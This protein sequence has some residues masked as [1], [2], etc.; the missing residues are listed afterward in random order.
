M[1][2]LLTF[3]FALIASVGI[4]SAQNGTCGD[5]LTWELNTE[6]GILTI[7]G[8][9]AMADYAHS[10]MPWYKYSSS[11]QSV[12][13]TDGVTSIG[14]HAFYCCFSLTSIT[15]PNGVTSIG[16]YA[17]YSCKS[18]ASITIPN[19]VTSIGNSAFYE[20]SSLTSVTI[21]NSVTSIDKNAFYYCS[22]LT[23]I[24]VDANN[25]NYSSTDG[26]LFNKDKTT[27]IE[28]PSGKQGVYTIPNSVTSIENGAFYSCKSLASITI[29]N[30]VT[31][32]GN[33]AFY[34]CS[35][36][37]SVTIP[38][39]VTSIGSEAFCK[40]SS[41]TSVTIP[42][43]VTS[44][45]DSAFYYCSSLTSVIIPN[46]VTSIGRGAFYG[47][48]SLASITI[49]NSVTTIG[50]DAF[51]RCESLTSITIPNSVTSIGSYAFYYCSSLTS[52][53]I[54]NSVTSIGERAF[55]G[56][57]SLTS[58]TFGATTPPRIGYVHVFYDTNN[59]LFYVP[60]GT[61]E[62]YVA[63][64][65]ANNTI[66]VSRVIET[67]ASGTCGDNLTWKL[68]CDSVLTISGTGAMADYAYNTMPWYDYRSSILSVVISDGVT[69]IGDNAFTRYST[70]TSVTI[71]NSVTS[72]GYMAFCECTSLTNIIIGDGITRI[73]GGA[74]HHTPIFSNESVWE[75]EVLYIGKYLIAVSVNKQG[76]YT[77][78][79]GTLLIADG[80]FSDCSSLTSLT[81]PNSVTGI[82]ENAFLECSGLT[83]VTFEGSTPPVFSEN[84]F[85]FAKECPIYVPCGTKEAYVA[86]LNVNNTIDESRVIEK[87]PYT[88][89]IAS[90]DN[91][92]GSVIITQEP[93]TCAEPLIF[94]AD[95]AEGYRFAQWSDGNTDN[96]RSLILTQ[97][98]TLKAEFED[99]KYIV[100]WQD[101][102]GNVI[103]E[104]K[105]MQGEMPEYI[106]EEPAK[107]STAEYSY[108]FAG[109]LPRIKPVT[110]NI[111]YTT[112]FI[113][114]KLTPEKVYTVNINGEN[115]SLNIS[116]EYPEG[117]VVTVEAVADDCFKFEKW[118]DNNTDNP[119]TITVTEDSVLTAEFTKLIYTI[120]GA[121]QSST[122]GSVQV[123]NP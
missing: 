89:S 106:G 55:E 72:I 112:Y 93:T 61:K 122:G 12:I 81:I 19:S 30:N 59:C 26:V 20:C 41:L 52:V 85:Y 39:S 73:K 24:N 25:S 56:C 84:V 50:R 116:N 51:M 31:S 70:L 96:P 54:P 23:S 28:C 18:L 97:D 62:A 7:S 108:V 69:S 9:G 118:S 91:T 10:T 6:T 77:L 43:S 80:A 36:F 101:E 46:S 44:I 47:C 35:S 45:G 88:Y 64:L 17:F 49:P 121:N 1:K 100:I 37:T 15:I 86:A 42:N 57:K 5:N 63:A 38:N 13:I 110:E 60:C 65:N 75:N 3:L 102:E 87:S 113:P 78:K 98:T 90:S 11:I 21:P 109:W 95:A 67:I 58:V 40:C 123:V 48:S 105:V 79:E 4:A 22:S 83:S 114:Q 107:D 71:P 92:L 33:S 104:D 32:I 8:T 27:L 111:R 66:E 2:K 76:S 99:A 120:K 34:E 74:F 29:P 82:G 14:D 103:K 117:A 119:R 94:R 16:D 53:T 68:S 115:C